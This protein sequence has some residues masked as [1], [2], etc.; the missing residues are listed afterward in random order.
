MMDNQYSLKFATPAKLVTILFLLLLNNSVLANSE[1]ESQFN[2]G[3]THYEEEQYDKAIP[4]LESA[5]KLEPHNAQYH[6]ILA[7]SYG[8]EAEKVNWLKAM[9][10]AKKTLA[11]LQIAVELDENNLEYLDDL[12]DYYREAPGFLG[13]NT[14]KANE[15]EKQIEMLE[16]SKNQAVY[17]PG[18]I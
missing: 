2:Q 14:Q 16:K 7:K 6:H 13:G 17:Y 15:I 8:R 9:D 12:M 10:F 1:A 4:E 3:Y 18:Q 5:V 11:H